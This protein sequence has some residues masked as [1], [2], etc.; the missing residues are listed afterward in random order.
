M[1]FGDRRG[2][3]QTVC[4]AAFRVWRSAGRFFE[5]IFLWLVTNCFGQLGGGRFNCL[6]I[7]HAGLVPP[8][9]ANFETIVTWMS[10]NSLSSQ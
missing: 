9:R 4:L 1:L 5:I 7:W 2:R 3:R 8:R 6:D 10:G